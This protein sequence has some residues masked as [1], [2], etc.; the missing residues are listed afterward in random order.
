MMIVARSENVK[1]PLREDS[2]NFSPYQEAAQKA[3]KSPAVSPEERT[4]DND[5]S[6]NDG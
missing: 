5:G 6:W 2:L 3:Q 4:K 1:G